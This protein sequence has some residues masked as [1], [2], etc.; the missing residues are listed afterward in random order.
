MALLLI[1]SRFQA[2]SQQQIYRNCNV[3]KFIMP[4]NPSNLGRVEPWVCSKLWHGHSYLLTARI[5]CRPSTRARWKESL[6]IRHA[7]VFNTLGSTSPKSDHTE[8]EVFFP[9]QRKLMGL[10]PRQAPVCAGAGRRSRFRR[11]VPEGSG[12]FRSVLVYRF[13]RRVPEGSGEFR[14]KMV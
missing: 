3:V 2:F 9:Q 14:C 6:K 4:G 13:R 5:P 10:Q 8:L 7:F 11:K 1:P 12:E